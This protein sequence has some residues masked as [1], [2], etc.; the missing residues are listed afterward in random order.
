MEALGSGA[1]ELQAFGCEVGHAENRL[2]WKF[3]PIEDEHSN[4]KPHGL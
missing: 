3:S 2:S 4:L 1:E